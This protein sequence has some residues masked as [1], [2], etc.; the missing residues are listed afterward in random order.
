M[1]H[2]AVAKVSLVVTL[3]LMSLLTLP[4]YAGQCS[5]ANVAGSFG[6]AASG[7]VTTP[8]GTFVPAGAAGRITF[9]AHGNVAGTQTR[10]VG[11][12]ALDET[13]SGTFTVNPDCTGTFTVVVQP[14]TRTS[15]VDLVWTQN[16]DSAVAVFT[17]AGFT[18]TATAQRIRSKRPN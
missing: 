8:S 1:K 6:Y 11:G 5:P 2:H 3:A 9:D 17:T 7:F 18:L 16:A 12:S 10:V 14:D 15:T 13:F 4:A